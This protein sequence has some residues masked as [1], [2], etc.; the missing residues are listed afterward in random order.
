MGSFPGVALAVFAGFD[1][2]LGAAVAA[3][4][5]IAGI[6]LIHRQTAFSEDTGIG[7]LFVGMLA[8][9]VILLSRT[10]SFTG[11]LAS[12]LFGD[13]L[14]ATGS[15]LALLAVVTAVAVVASALLYRHFL[16]LAFNE[17]KAAL[18][19]LRPNLAHAALLVLI[20]LAVIGSYRTVGALLVFGMLVGPPATAS[21]LVRRVPTMMVT[22]AAIGALSAAAGLV[23]S[24]H[25]GTSGSATMALV[26][27]VLF[28]IVLMATSR[29][30]ARPS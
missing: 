10:P 19:G 2:T 11:T 7:L 13:A 22:A 3:A 29:R 4:V 17:Q 1:P 28:F 16:V 14:G 30:R 25:A 12:I 20:T 23:I 15:D 24:Y 6:N 26:P 27:I 18:L 8:L 9:G 21:L 5:M